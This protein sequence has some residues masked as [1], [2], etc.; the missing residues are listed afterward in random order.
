MTHEVERILA[1]IDADHGD[2]C[3]EVLRHGVLLDLSAPCQL[4]ALAGPEHG[5]TIPF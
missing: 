5:R 3:V 1:D 2:R 4:L